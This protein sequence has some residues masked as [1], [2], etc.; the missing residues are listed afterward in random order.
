M[1]PSIPPSTPKVT[2]APTTAKVEA[3][4][5]KPL[6]EKVRKAL[7]LLDEVSV[8]LAKPDVVYANLITPQLNVA[9]EA[10]AYVALLLAQHE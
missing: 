6:S 5:G 4:K 8:D 3:P 7:A 10:S 2:P 9:R 1:T